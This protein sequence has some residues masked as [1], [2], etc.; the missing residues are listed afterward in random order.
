MNIKDQLFGKRLLLL[1]DS[2]STKDIIRYAQKQ[3]V[4][5]IL[6]DHLPPETSLSKLLAD[7]YW[8]VSTADVDTLEELVK[9]NSI[10]GIFAGV[11]EFNLEKAK[12]LCKRCDLPFYA[13]DHQWEIATNKEKFKK[14]CHDFN[15]QTPE[16]IVV[17][18]NKTN[19]HNKQF[20]FPVVVK[21]VDSRAGMGV[22]ICNDLEELRKKYI[23]SKS[24]SKSG[25][26]LVEPLITSEQV[27]IYYAIQKGEISLLS[28]ADRY[29]KNQ[30]DGNLPLPAA[31][32]FPSKH[33]KNYTETLD[34][35]VK[36]MI[37]SMGIQNGVLLIQSFV[38]KESFIFYEMGFRLNGSMEYKITSKLN[39]INSLEMMTNYALTGL[40]YDKLIK[41]FVNPFYLNCGCVMY[42]VVKPGKIGKI[43][44]VDEVGSLP[45][46]IDIDAIYRE[47]D[48]IHESSVGTLKQVILKVFI[49]T[50]TKTKLVNVMSQV[51]EKIKVND[52]NGETL[53]LKGVEPADL[54]QN[55]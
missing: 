44:G 38:K 48:V 13:A 18:P 25:K 9:N 22:F 40:L 39:N 55:D 26:V 35:K 42:F 50:D 53:L 1:G 8:D 43:I 32:I 34:A 29:V 21:P 14:L 24:F 16:N 54:L 15:I 17:D 11:S 31:F 12:L 2:V 30:Q 7:E 20:N 4:F 51:Y 10:D 28:V 23:N 5:V 19:L 49:S 41:K 37:N 33:L 45:E 3:G 47:G 46:I 6:T 36:Q 27:N 52:I